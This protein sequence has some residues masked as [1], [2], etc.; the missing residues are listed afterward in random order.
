MN[1]HTPCPRTQFLRRLSAVSSIAAVLV[2]AHAGGVRAQPDTSDTLT[3]TEK[4]ALE[5]EE[6]RPL[7]KSR[8]VRHFLDA[9]ADLPAIE[10]RVVLHDSSRTHY[11]TPTEAQAL[12]DSVRAKLVTR[13]LDETFYYNT[14]YGS[15]LA[16]SRAL[17]IASEA[18]LDDLLGKRVLDFGYGTAGHLRLMACLGANVVGVDVDPLLPKLYREPGDQGPVEGREKGTLKLVHGHFPAGEGVAGAVG[19]GYDLFI[20]KNTLKNGY[21]HPAQKVDPRFLV[22]LGVDDTTFVR[23]VFRILKPGGRAL[24]YNLCPAPNAPDKPYRPHADGRCPFPAAL[25]QHAGFTVVAFD[26]DDNAEARAMAH[27]LGWDQGESAMKLEQ[28][29]FASYTLVQKPARSRR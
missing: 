8:L 2:A 9:T 25:W 1:A 20:S 16:Y 3:Q 23:E 28:D 6:L 26:V 27:A 13:N 5:A 12:P 17:D 29:L 22:H 15:P 4:L 18:G 21:I 19:E 24:I 7:A 10:P 11:Y 14:R